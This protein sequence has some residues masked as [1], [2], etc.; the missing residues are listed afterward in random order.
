MVRKLCNA[1]GANLSTV[2]L[3]GS[4]AAGE[5]QTEH[6][7]LNLLC[8]L[9]CVDPAELRKLHSSVRWW[10][11]RGH[12][13]PLFFTLEEIVSAADLYAIE[14]MEI[15]SHRRILFGEDS[16]ESLDVPDRLHRQQVEREL[17]QSLIRLRQG[18]VAAAEDEKAL[19][20]LML[21][22]LSTFGLLFRHALIAL[23]DA[24]PHSKSEAV[25]RLA[26]RLSFDPSGFRELFE[27]RHGKRR[28]RDMNARAVFDRY[29]EGVTR[30]ANGVDEKFAALSR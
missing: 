18:Y 17:R 29:L 26:E 2:A 5:F 12:P 21:R 10:S 4:A 23:G 24:A 9:R 30:A 15:K 14:L 13:A 25:E 16:F 3:Y 11:R 19:R 28:E 27:V 7:D 6:S 8:L 1:A 22:S 20:K